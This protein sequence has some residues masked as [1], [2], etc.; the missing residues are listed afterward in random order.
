MYE[1]IKAFHNF[2][3]LYSYLMLSSGA[4]YIYPYRCI[5]SESYTYACCVCILNL[6][7]NLNLIKLLDYVLIKNKFLIK[8]LPAKRVSL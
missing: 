1:L 2:R 5:K 7:M 4:I 3:E 6:C 8:T